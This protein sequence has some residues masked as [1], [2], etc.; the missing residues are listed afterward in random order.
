M[1]GP[2]SNTRNNLRRGRA[3]SVDLS[4]RIQVED[5]VHSL[6]VEMGD[7]DASDNEGG[8][9]HGQ[10][11]RRKGSVRVPYDPRN[12][13]VVREM[14]AEAVRSARN[15]WEQAFRTPGSAQAGTN[16]EALP[17][18]EVSSLPGSLSD[19]LKNREKMEQDMPS[20]MPM[21]KW[22]TFQ[23]RG[24][25]DQDPRDRVLATGLTRPRRA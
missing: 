11:E 8:G 4:P 19:L 6:E 14:I 17:S 7:G 12:D 13:P 10:D 21:W 24:P 15:D 18:R 23:P 5:A 3:E 1:A 22:P 20:M 2:A 16:H 9:R 25:K